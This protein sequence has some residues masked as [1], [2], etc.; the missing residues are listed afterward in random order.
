MCPWN[1]RFSKEL[2]NDSP[3]APREAL[4]GKDARQ[5]ARELLGMSQPEFSAAFKGS[6]MK[7]AKLRGL[8]RNA[9][10]VLGNVGTADDVDVL[11]R[12]L[13]D[14]EPLVREHAA[15]VLARLAPR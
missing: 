6:P 8:K 15:W 2:P 14:P 12:A 9:A 1:V 3:Y 4:A 7:R 11:T 5:L 10:V 13:D